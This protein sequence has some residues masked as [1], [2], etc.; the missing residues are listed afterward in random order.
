FI[1]NTLHFRFVW[2][3]DFQVYYLTS[4]TC[5]ELLSRHRRSW[6]IDSFTIE[7]GHPG[8]FP[9]VLGKVH[10]DRAYQVS[11]DLFGEGMDKE[12]KGLLSIDKESGTVS[13][14]RAVDYEQKATLKLKF[15]A[16]KKDL[17]I[18]TNLGIEIS[19][20]DINDNP[21]RFHRDLYDINIDE[22]TTQGFHVLTVL[23]YDRDQTGTPNSTFHYKIKSVS[24]NTPDTEF[25][26][27]SESGTISFKGCLDHEVAEMFT[28]VVEAKDHGD[29][30]S[31]SS[32]TV[33]VIH[34]QDG[35]NHLPTFSG[36]TVRSKVKEHETGASPLRLH[37]TDKDT[38]NSQAWRARYT[39]QGDEGKHFK[40]ETDP[41]TNDGILTVIKPLD[42]EEE[43]QRELYISVENEAPYFSCKVKEKTPSGLWK[44]DHSKGDDSPSDS[45]KVIVEVEDANDPP[46]FSVTVK[47]ARLEEDVPIGTWVGK[48]TAVDP[49]SSHAKDFLYKVGD[50]PAGWVTV[51]PHTGDITTAEPPDRESPHV[52]NGVYT[53]LL[54]AV[55]DG[56][57]PMTGTAT[58]NI[59]VIDQNDNV[60]QPTVDYL[61]VCLSDGPAT[62]NITAFDLDGNPF[63]GPFTFELLGDVEGKWKLNPS[64]GYTAGLVRGP[65]VYAGPHTI[66]LKISDLQGMFG[67]YD[68]S[69]TV[70]DCS[71]VPN[72]RRHRG[73]VTKAAPGA[74]VIALVSL[75]LLLFV[76]LIAVV[77]TCKKEFVPLQ[78]SDSSGETLLASN[79]EKPGTDCKVPD[80]ILV[81]VADETHHVPSNWQSQHDGIQHSK[82]SKV[83]THTL[84]TY[85]LA[86]DHSCSYNSLQQDTEQ[87]HTNLRDHRSE[88][89]SYLFNENLYPTTWNSLLANSY[90]YTH[91]TEY[92]STM[93]VNS[94]HQRDAAL[95]A[96]INQRLSSLQDIED[97]L[98]YLPHLYKDEGDSDS[99]SELENIIPDED[100]YQNVL[101]DLGPGFEQLASICKPPHT[102]N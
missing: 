83:P 45:V 56:K 68:F 25:T 77:I 19:I 101:N 10:I 62:T 97:Q 98:D 79:I 84:K 92:M 7:E 42:H 31:L 16:R 27:D 95:L 57:P 96:V 81:A 34:V 94:S 33:V 61:D 46:V 49:D 50:D 64:N 9:Y 39:I 65:G 51:D 41:D 55:D 90:H 5:S 21:P 3:L 88:E 89:V 28:V 15:E 30:V 11:F 82:V 35:N 60:P 63:G 2:L 24:P 93:N 1:V 4:A 71:V 58:L 73:S 72:C 36:Q 32:S 20:L 47:E 26:I 44:V 70:C 59:H 78:T 14:H 91:Q 54:H 66:N 67:V 100:S 69:V 37:L 85:K 74:I 6:I 17:S 23:A 40:I 75:F 80:N 22:E 8:P 48:V 99:D 53:I 43:T 102:Q 12:P 29:V 86:P 18:D 87:N 52:V 38:P 76:L 13:V